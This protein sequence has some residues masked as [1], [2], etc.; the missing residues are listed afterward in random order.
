MY[1]DA[2]ETQRGLDSLLTA[3]RMVQSDEHGYARMPERLRQA[4]KR[5]IVAVR[6]DL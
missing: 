4:L 5:K 3:E 6:E 2:N 1:L